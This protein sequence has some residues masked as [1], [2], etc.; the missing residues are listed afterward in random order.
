MSLSDPRCPWL[1][2]VAARCIQRNPDVVSC[3][4]MYVG[5]LVCTIMIND[6]S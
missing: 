5:V 3:T 2:I 1:H 6:L 4:K